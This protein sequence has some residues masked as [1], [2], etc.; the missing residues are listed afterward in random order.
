M[1]D[2]VSRII[3]NYDDTDFATKVMVELVSKTM[4]KFRIY[5][6]FNIDTFLNV[7]FHPNRY[8]RRSGYQLQQ[9]ILRNNPKVTSEHLQLLIEIGF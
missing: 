1:L 3:L 2:S 5:D 4:E 8:I 6:K 9:Q 7:N